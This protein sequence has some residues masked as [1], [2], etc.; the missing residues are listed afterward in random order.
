MKFYVAGKWEDRKNIRKLM[1]KIRGFGHAITYDWTIDEEL[2]DREVKT[3]SDTRGVQECDAYVGRFIEKNH[4]RGAL[5]ELGIALGLGKRIYIIGHSEDECI[6][7]NHP[8]VQRF[9]DELGF[10]IFISWGQ[11]DEEGDFKL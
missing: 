10:L 5:V 7:T 4:Y 6:F 9:P 3:M 2:L 1:D 11:Y 8:S